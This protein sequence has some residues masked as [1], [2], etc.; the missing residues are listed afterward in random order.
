MTGVDAD[1][2]Q[3]VLGG[4]LLL[5]VLANR[6]LNWPRSLGPSDSWPRS[7][8]RPTSST[9]TSCRCSIRARQTPLPSTVPPALLLMLAR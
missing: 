6:A 3:V 1:W 8:P 7:R 2:Y 5:A 9:R 4:M